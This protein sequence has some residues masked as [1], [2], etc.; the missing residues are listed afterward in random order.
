MKRRFADVGLVWTCGSETLSRAL[1]YFWPKKA[2]CGWRLVGEGERLAQLAFGG[3]GQDLVVGGDNDP[4]VRGLG[5]GVDAGAFG[6][7][8]RCRQA[9]GRRALQADDKQGDDG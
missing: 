9:W 3:E 8:E 4:E 7:V 6:Q 1:G 5:D 2:G